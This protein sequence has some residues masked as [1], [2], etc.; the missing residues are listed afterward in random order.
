MCINSLIFL[1]AFSISGIAEEKITIIHAGTLITDAHKAAQSAQS[2]QSIIVAGDT[3]SAVKDGYISMDDARIIDLSS[4]FVLPGLIDTHIHLQFSG[5]SLNK[6]LTQME[7]GV[8]TLRAYAQA[9]RSLQAGFTTL[10]DM[11]GDPDVIFS[12][13]DAIN[14]GI[15]SGPRIL[16]AGPA[17][18]PTG[19]G[20]IRGFRGDVMSLLEDSNLEYP[21]D[22]ADDCRK[23]ARQLV[24]QGA[25]LIKI[26]ATA[27]ITA[28]GKAGFASQMTFVEL[29]AIVDTA[30]ALN[31]KVAAHA[32]GL[33][34]LNMA[35]EAGVDSIEHGTFGDR[36]SIKLYKKNKAYLVATPMAG[37]VQRARNSTSMSVTQRD[38]ILHAGEYWYVMT[39]L[40]YKNGVKMAFGSD[41][42]VGGHG[43]NALNFRHYQQ[44]GMSNADII[45]SATGAAAG[46]LGM[47]S[48]T[49]IIETG[50]KA[51]IIAS[52]ENPLKS[53]DALFDIHFVMKDGELIKGPSRK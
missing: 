37:L 18:M 4:S 3:I 51:D 29:K 19:G 45:F 32:H 9:N 10:R 1:L 21:C 48:Q 6:D 30:H 20:V 12:L 41:I 11:A 8:T 15:V 46:L 38:K 53:I 28:Q 17:I 35:L 42:N 24:K 34:G 43:E 47:T 33:A 39:G 40:S 25:D 49:G 5:A 7:D 52:S 2:A 23:A 44:A 27:S 26:V 13:R 36:S 50:K 31:R 14:Q 22:G 16:A